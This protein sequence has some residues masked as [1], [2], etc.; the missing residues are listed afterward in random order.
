V[1]PVGLGARDTLRLEAGMPLYGNELGPDT[2]PFEAGLGRV[3][4][5]AKEGGFVG[6]DALAR[7]AE[8]GPRRQLVGLVVRGRGIA[9]HGYPVLDADGVT[10]VVT[11]GTMSPTLGVAIAMAYVAPAHA[12]PGTMLDV[13]IRGARVAAEVVP[14]PFYKRPA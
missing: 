14:L 11:S 8:A 1:A 12:Q 6:R 13:E 2:T 4:K 3:V 5:L 10:G 9:R 7:A